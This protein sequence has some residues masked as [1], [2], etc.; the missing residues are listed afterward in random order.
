MRVSN[1][2][3]FSHKQNFG[4]LEKWLHTGDGHLQC[5]RGGSPMKVQLYIDYNF[6]I[7][8]WCQHIPTF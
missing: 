7:S 8:F 1:Y 4:I 2:S 6:Y 3:D 5:M